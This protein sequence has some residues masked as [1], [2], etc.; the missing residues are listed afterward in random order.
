MAEMMHI[1][2]AQIDTHGTGAMLTLHGSQALASQ[3]K[4]RIPAD[5]FPIA[6]MPAQRMFQPVGIGL[7]IQNGVALGTDV[8]M[9]ERIGIV[10]ANGHQTPRIELELQ[11]A[12]RFAKRTGA[13]TGFTGHTQ[14]LLT[15]RP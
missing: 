5:F 14:L 10:A 12:D 1:G 11:A 3:R 2:I 6:A 4:G 8:A 7:Q 9:A 15:M 13:E